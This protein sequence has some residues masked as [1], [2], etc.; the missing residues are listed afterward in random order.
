MR[1]LQ[2][3]LFWRIV[4]SCSLTHVERLVSIC[5][6]RGSHDGD[7]CMGRGWETWKIA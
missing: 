1:V 5:D 6:F 3:K 4:T 7:R 2:S